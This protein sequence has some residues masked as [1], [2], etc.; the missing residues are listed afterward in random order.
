MAEMPRGGEK[1]MPSIKVEKQGKMIEIP[2]IPGERVMELLLQ[3]DCF[4]DNPCSGRGTCG[5]CRVQVLNGRLGP[6]GNT[7]RKFLS[8]EELDKGIRLACCLQ[9]ESD[10][11]LALLQEEKKH[12]ILSSGYMPELEKDLRLHKV[13]PHSAG[14]YTAF[15]RNGRVIDTEKGDTRA[16]VYGIAVD[17][18]TTTVAAEL[19][20][21]RDGK[22]LSSAA[23]INPQ[24][25]FGFDVLSRISHE[26]ENPDQGIQDLQGQI[27]TGLNQLI[28]A[29]CVESG[30]CRSHI[31]DISVAANTTMLHML[32]GIDARSLGKAPFAPVFTEAKRVKAEE[33]GLRLPHTAEL[34][35]LPSVSAYIGADIVAGVYVCKLQEEKGKVLFVDIGTNG[36]I[37]L[38]VGG[39]LLSCSAAAGPALE[40]MNISAGMRA[41]EGAVEDLR[42]D[43]KG[44]SLKVIGDVPPCGICGSGIIAAVRE[45]LKVGLLKKEGAFIKKESMAKEDYRYALLEEDGRRRRVCLSSEQN[46]RVSQSDIRQ[47]QLA[48]GAILSGF[49][50][51]LKQ[52]KLQMEDLDK[53]VIAGQFGKYLPVESLTAV[54][55]IPKDIRDR[56]VYVG[57]TAKTG[58]YMALLS[59]KCKED[60]ER[61][62]KEISY[63]ELGTVPFYERLFSEC[64]IFPEQ[65]T[66]RGAE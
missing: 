22:V 18:G 48:K 13:Y 40:G 61:L 29:L 46:I 10:L 8:P 5:K 42:I 9:P 3:A 6:A 27:V 4:I 24:K 50:A 43:E 63:L 45:L 39:K 2:F 57:N 16:H 25:Q 56:I 66:C 53:V 15:M 38:S 21:L 52:A 23:M 41:A 32:L 28:D 1:K 64:L 58:A 55:I 44:I 20:D 35:C 31:Y 19:V 54:G 12:T 60:M 37:V 62:A 49:L 36:E 14:D 11:E 65:D 33:I 51:L 7:E 30:I 34:Y 59:E 17:I 26:I 47:V